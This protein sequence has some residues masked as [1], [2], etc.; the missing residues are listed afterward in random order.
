MSKRKRG[1]ER[2]RERESEKEKEKE[3]KANE[4]KGRLYFSSSL[5]PPVPVHIL[6]EVPVNQLHNCYR[7]V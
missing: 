1:R 5:L 3:R 6:S 2:K 7:N 4:F